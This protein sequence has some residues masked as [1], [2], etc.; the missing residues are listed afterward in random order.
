MIKPASKGPGNGQLTNL[1]ME[2]LADGQRR[3]FHQ[4]QDLTQ[5]EA[6]MKE[7]LE[8]TKRR[9]AELEQVRVLEFHR[10]I[11]ANENSSSLFF[12][13]FQHKIAARG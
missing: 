13:S 10:R 12:A 5:S 8:A 2:I 1:K 6:N 9:L 11:L 3:L 4:V 7:E